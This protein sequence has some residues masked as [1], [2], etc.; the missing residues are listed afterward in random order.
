[1]INLR[2]IFAFSAL[3]SLLVIGFACTKPEQEEKKAPQ[4]E[5]QTSVKISDEEQEFSVE[6]EIK[7][8]VEGVSL[9][10]FTKADWLNVVAVEPGAVKLK[11]ACNESE[12]ARTTEVLLSYEGAANVKI[13]VLQSAKAVAPKTLTFEI[14]IKKIT[15]RTVTLDCIPSDLEAT[16]RNGCR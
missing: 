7:N 5:V 15:S 10:A 3:A 16:Y 8:P 4:I 2:K 11:A 12:L 1:M 13:D 9:E 14:T 6:Y